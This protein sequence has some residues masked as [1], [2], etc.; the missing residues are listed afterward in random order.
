MHDQRIIEFV[1]ENQGCSKE[2]VVNGTGDLSRVPTINRLNNLIKLGIIITHAKGK[3]YRN[4][5]YVSEQDLISSV[6]RQLHAFERNYFPLLS[7]VIRW[8]KKPDVLVWKQFKHKYRRDPTK[9]DLHELLLNVLVL[10]QMMMNTYTL[11]SIFEWPQLIKDREY[12][13]T[14]NGAVF[15]RISELYTNIYDK[16]TSKKIEGI[17]KVIDK[18]LKK[19]YPNEFLDYFADPFEDF[20]LFEDLKKVGSSGLINY[21]SEDVPLDESLKEWMG[22]G[23]SRK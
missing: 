3:K 6:S 7:K 13:V 15:Q 22:S 8:T 20:G 16:L 4:R 21:Q 1:V 11:R 5:L 19:I 9:E 14:L 17:D 23:T 2:D 12:L 18:A 10:F